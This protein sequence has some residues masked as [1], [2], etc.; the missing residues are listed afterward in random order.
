MLRIVND[1]ELN[2]VRIRNVSFFILL[3]DAARE[4]DCEGVMVGRNAVMNENR[5]PNEIAERNS[6][7]FISGKLSSCFG[8][9]GLFMML[10]NNIL[11]PN[12]PERR[13]RRG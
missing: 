9:M 4:E 5:N 10:M 3:N 2:P 13:G 11:V 6:F 12:K 8:I 1:A 7:I